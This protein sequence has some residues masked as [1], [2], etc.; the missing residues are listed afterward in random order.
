ME[1]R[2]LADLN[3]LDRNLFEN[4]VDDIYAA[5]VLLTLF[6]GKVAYQNARISIGGIRAPEGSFH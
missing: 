6:E 5:S 2:K 3:V 1:V 4:P